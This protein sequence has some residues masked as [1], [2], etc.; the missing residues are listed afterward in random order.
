MQLCIF[1]QS[2]DPKPTMWTT[3]A[4]TKTTSKLNVNQK[5]EDEDD[6]G[7]EDEDDGNIEEL[8]K[9]KKVKGERVF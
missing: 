3:K 6:H 1:P 8:R 2:G 9:T 5:T 4:T 7:D